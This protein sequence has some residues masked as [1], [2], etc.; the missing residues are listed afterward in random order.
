VK[1]INQNL[2]GHWREVTIILLWT[3]NMQARKINDF[4]EINV[5]VIRRIDYFAL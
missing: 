3:C 4:N 2:I 1:W 5:C